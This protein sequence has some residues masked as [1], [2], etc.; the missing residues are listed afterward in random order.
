MGIFKK[1]PEQEISSEIE[2]LKET[3]LSANM[4]EVVQNIALKEIERLRKTS[5]SSAEYTIGINY[6]DYLVSLPWNKMTDDN[7]D[8][9]RAA[10]ILDKEHFGLSDIKDRILE[11][12]AVRI[13]KLSRKHRI[14]IVDDEEMTR[15]NLEHVFLKDGY[16]VKTAASGIEALDFLKESAFDVIVTDLK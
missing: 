5:P 7:L 14:L 15:R 3:V 8:I 4:T 9:K 6:I 10:H 16:Y 1:D 2:E 13:L 11:H 12:L